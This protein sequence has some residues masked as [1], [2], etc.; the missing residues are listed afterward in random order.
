M[1]SVIHSEAANQKLVFS[2]S[3]TYLSFFR[4]EKV[5]IRSEES[6]T[7]DKTSITNLWGI[8]STAL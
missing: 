8:G 2:E 3:E 1:Q 6:N 5:V 7:G 4:G